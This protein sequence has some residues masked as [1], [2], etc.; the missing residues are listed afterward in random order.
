VVLVA[1]CRPAAPP[2][3]VAVPEPAPRIETARAPEPP[4]R[5]VVPPAPVKRGPMAI[6]VVYPSRDQLIAARDSNFILGNI[7]TGDAE[8]TINGIPVAV[9]PSG[10]FL[11]WLPVPSDDRAR[12]VLLAT[13]GA[14]TVQRTLDVRVARRTPL[15]ATGRLRVDSASA[16]PRGSLSYR[17][18]DRLR[19]AVRAPSNAR[20]WVQGGDGRRVS[21]ASTRS[22]RQAQ[23]RMAET[24]DAPTDSTRD[25][26]VTFATDVAARW[27]AGSR[28]AR[29]VVGRGRDTVRLELP[30]VAL[31]DS[32]ER[33]VAMLRSRDV[34]VG[35][36]DRVVIGRP[37][38]AGTYRWFLLPG[39]IVEVTG[40]QNGWARIRLDRAL[41]IWV[42]AEDL[43]ELPDGAALPR[44][45]TGGARLV[46]AE[47][48]VDITIPMAD[49]P[50]YSVAQG[51]RSLRVTLYDVQANPEISPILGNDSLVQQ[52]AWEQPQSDRAVLTVRLGAPLYGYR[53]FWDDA[54]SQFVLRVRRVPALDALQPLR[55]L[56]L[57]VDPGHPP[58]GA[59]GPS[60]IT[61]AAAVLPVGLEVARLLEARGASVVVTRR[62]MAP[63]G[64]LE[65]TVIAQ[66]VD[67][68]AFL[69][70]HLNA[71]PDGV[72]PF[73]ASGT[74]TLFFHQMSEP[75]AREVQRA[76]MPRLGLRD[77]G[78]HYQNL[79]ISRPTWYPS[80]LAEGLFLIVPE[81]E[82]I[83]L[84]AEGQR[85]YAEGI[86]AG[87]EAYF[88]SLVGARR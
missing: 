16:E 73:T 65:R 79:A 44:R 7:G 60:G 63:V 80:A 34:V 50:A 39:T 23:A 48:W 70:V 45:V 52:L 67:A 5:V 15:V 66:R 1:S 59:T 42:D 72:N 36:T 27:F 56:R 38:P 81:Q 86:V 75:L 12:Y 61:E 57:V 13:R 18:D 11:G 26:G 30:R 24:A 55:G 83:V 10:T 85:A 25:V 9:H 76:L 64:L 28:A 17:A 58:A 78:V 46:P 68:H 8:L 40:R 69:S 53:A 20:V 74:S 62:D 87:V 33:R 29:L 37:V 3:T 14:D 32:A 88:R 47:E 82:A 71:L 21:L 19:V 2:A 43:A 31:V 4:A 49:R 51:P 6:R 41:E 84:S 77:L 22:V 54:R 35:D